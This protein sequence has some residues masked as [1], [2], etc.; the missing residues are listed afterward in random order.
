[1]SDLDANVVLHDSGTGTPLL[2]LHCL[3]VD[4]HFWDF[5][6]A[7]NGELRLLRYDLPGHGATSVPPAAYTIEDL[8]RQLLAIL[9]RNGIAKAHVAGISWGG[10]IAQHFAATQPEMVDHLML[11]DTTPRY[12]DELQ[13]MWRVRADTARKQGVEALVAGLLPIWFS[14]ECLAAD[15]APVRY[16]RE[17]LARTP[18]EGYAL[19]CE[20][21]AA[22][23]LRPLA[24][25]INAPT[26]VVCGDND[27]PSFLDAAHWLTD[28]IADARLCWIPKTRHA[29]VLEAPE[30]ALQLMREFFAALN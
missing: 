29:S 9:R 14:A 11:V 4:H 28:N 8:S 1:M 20:A 7:L 5:T 19:A 10:L 26:M 2:L 18:G 13:G 6:T 25:Q 23:D 12:S 24:A 30:R 27:I 21:L 3:G 15:A 16:L 17:T 22:A